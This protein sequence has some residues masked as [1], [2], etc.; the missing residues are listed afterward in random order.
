MLKML[1]NLM[2]FSGSGDCLSALVFEKKEEVI[3]A[4]DF[5]MI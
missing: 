2:A 4:Y 5:K 3:S 1:V